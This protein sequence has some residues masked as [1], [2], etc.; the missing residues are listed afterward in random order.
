MSTVWPFLHTGDQ[1]FIDWDEF[2]TISKLP[3]ETMVKETM[4]KVKGKGEGHWYSQVKLEDRILGHG[5]IEDC[6]GLHQA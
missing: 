2:T 6:A 5:K 1:G 4:V 3:K